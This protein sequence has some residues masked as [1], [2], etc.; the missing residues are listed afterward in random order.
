MPLPEDIHK[1]ADWFKHG[2]PTPRPVKPRKPKAVAKPRPKGEAR[3][4]P[5][6]VKAVL[7]QVTETAVNQKMVARELAVSVA[8]VSLLL[9]DK[10]TGDLVVM[11]QRIRGCYMGAVV[12][13]P[14]Y[15]TLA[16][17]K[18]LEFQALPPAFTN[19][20]R[21]ML[22]QRCPTC[23]HNRRALHPKATTPSAKDES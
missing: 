2:I 18:C 10:Y 1:N 14:V 11:A 20:L 21:S 9:A 17:N 7:V 13:C 22:A 16:K 12:R 19:P 23:P 4:L 5:A 6:D 3:P 15:G 8:A